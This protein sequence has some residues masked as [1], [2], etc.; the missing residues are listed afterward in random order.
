[1]KATTSIFKILS[2]VILVAAVVYFGVQTYRYLTDPINTTVVYA[3]SEESVM[4][5]NGYLIREEET[6]H[7]DAGTLGHALS[8]GER[9]G[10][11]QTMAV[12]Y[13]DSGALTRVERLEALKLKKEQLS[14]S[15]VSYLDPDAALKLDSSINSDILSLRRSVAGGEYGNTEEQL[16]SLKGAI[17]KRDYTSA[18]QE[19]IEAGIKATEEEI[20]EMERSLNGR[21]ITAPQ[22][23]IYSAACDGYESVL[24]MDFLTDDL[25]PSKLGSVRPLGSDNAN[26]G[27]LIYGDAWYYAAN[28]TD[29]QAQQLEGRS[30]VTLRFAKGLA[31][32]LKMTVV[33]LSRSENGQRTLVLRSDK[34]LAQT[35]LLRHQAATLVLRTYEGLRLPSN[36][37]RVNEE[38][39]SG[40]Y[41]VLGVRAKFKPVR[42]VYQGEGYALVEAASAVE[43]ST[44]LRQGD[45]VIV[46]TAQLY[47]GKVI[48]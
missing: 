19:E 30:T 13:A 48:G 17:L 34:Y 45:Q 43:D 24:T 42:V 21:A 16:A 35:T 40:V 20:G 15:L 3:S 31:M 10:K 7:S 9:V 41:C 23:G 25:T 36:A 47:D 32:D 14:F 11:G 38:G 18:T 26:V 1:M 12:A 46:T 4:E 29:R 5:V 39:I 22:S 37:L 27:K 33:S 44:L 28:I 2:V 6:F 8:E